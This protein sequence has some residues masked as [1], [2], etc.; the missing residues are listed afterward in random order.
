MIAQAEDHDQ[1][2]VHG[3]V[4]LLL[5]QQMAPPP[6]RTPTD[7]VAAGK[8]FQPLKDVEIDFEIDSPFARH[9][10]GG[11]NFVVRK[12]FEVGSLQKGDEFVEQTFDLRFQLLSRVLLEGLCFGI[13]IEVLVGVLQLFQA[14]L[15]FAMQRRH[16]APAE[17][18]ELF[19]VG[20][21]K[22]RIGAQQVDQ[23]G[24]T[25]GDEMLA[26][27]VFSHTLLLKAALS[28]GKPEMARKG[29]QF[30]HS[31][32][33]R[34]DDFSTPAALSCLGILFSAETAATGRVFAVKIEEAGS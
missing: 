29:R 32:F 4:D 8:Q 3:N 27:R 33:L 15:V 12:S 10:G 28:T 5:P 22:Q 7:N 17:P 19:L 26:I 13:G 6:P 11:G 2:L 25:D 18:P 23:V 21:R 9:L 34:Q 20:P 31:P 1:P 30:R 24:L 14:R 16:E